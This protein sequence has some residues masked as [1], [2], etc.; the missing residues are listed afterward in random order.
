M[1]EPGV[2]GWCWKS[3][4]A[5][6]S[7]NNIYKY[8]ETPSYNNRTSKSRELFHYPLS[9][10]LINLETIAKNPKADNKAPMSSKHSPLNLV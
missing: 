9:T 2:V 7:L 10:V 5:S 1:E 4:L 8:T 3:W 6:L